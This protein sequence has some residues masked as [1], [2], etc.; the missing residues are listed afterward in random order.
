MGGALAK[1]LQ[2]AAAE[3]KAAGKIT[4]LAGKEAVRGVKEHPV[5]AALG[6]GAGYGASEVLEEE[7]DPIKK[8]LAALGIEG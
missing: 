5:I 6:A 8:L 3:G 1:F 2:R 4:K 7:D